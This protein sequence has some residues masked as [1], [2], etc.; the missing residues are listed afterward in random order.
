MMKL[1][2]LL[3]IRHE[4]LL[5]LTALILIVAEIFIDDKSK[6]K[7]VPLALF[8]MIVVTAAGILFPVNGTAFGGMYQTDALRSAMKTILDIAT[9]IIILQSY[10]WVSKKVNQ[11]KTSEFY[12]LMISTLVGMN[13]MI[14]SGDFLMLYLGLELAT[15]PIAAMA[16]FDRHKSN[17]AEAGIKLILSSA[18][19][20]AVLLYGLSL[21]YGTTGS[22]YFEEVRAAFRIEP[23]P[24]LGLV[25][26]VT[27]MGFKI[28]L[29][30]FHLWTA[31]VYE[32]SPIAVT[33]FLSVVS[34]GAAVFIFTFVLYTVFA[35]VS[36]FWSQ[37]LVVLSVTTMTVGNL[38]ALRQ[39]NMKRFLAF[40]S[41]AQAGFI[42]LGILGQGEQGFGSVI[43]FLL[44]YV[45]TNLAAFSVVAAISD[46][47]GK[48]NMADYNGLYKTNPNLS[49]IM[50]L[51]LFSLA[52]IPPVAGFFGKL[53]LFS[54]AAS[55]GYYWL[56]FVAVMNATISLYYYLRPVRAMFIEKNDN[57]IPTFKS[58]IY[59]RIGIAVSVAGIF[60]TGFISAIY[61]Y[62]LSI[63]NL[64]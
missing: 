13:F 20:S 40:S 33:S 12:I 23:L 58:D 5:T 43:F 15:I 6:K 36:A 50:M 18:L 32:G 2:D 3:L 53:F 24:I 48:E 8:L 11:N 55:N 25:F 19:S 31:D 17:S 38:F 64:F 10:G 42:L 44:V 28:S 34:K 7:I 60:L 62:Y 49:L 35:P 41:I 22:I 57:P 63:S 59:M 61:E 54:A 9:V 14:S 4:L 21:I 56:L 51:A 47:T 27:G 52:G 1:Q 26:F 39:E 37:V 30:P 46:K 29:V 45:F 16:A